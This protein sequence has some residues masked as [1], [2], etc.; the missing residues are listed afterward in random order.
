MVNKTGKF[1]PSII[2]V[3]RGHFKSVLVRMGQVCCSNKQ[4]PVSRLKVTTQV[5]F[6][7]MPHIHHGSPLRDQADGVVTSQTLPV[8]APAGKNVLEDLTTAVKS[9]LW[10]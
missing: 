5:Y 9:L 3:G 4:P 8:T 6:F 1:S 10:K 2:I 7:L